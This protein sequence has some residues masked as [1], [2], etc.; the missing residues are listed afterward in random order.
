[1][2]SVLVAPPLRQPDVHHPHGHRVNVGII[3]TGK[4]VYRG[5]A[6]SATA[7]YNGKLFL[8]DGAESHSSG[9]REWR[10]AAH[11]DE[12][13]LRLGRRIIAF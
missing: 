10:A 12:R 3:E 9:D 5:L 13:S 7:F 11:G 4:R 8:F 6:E 1:M 2:K